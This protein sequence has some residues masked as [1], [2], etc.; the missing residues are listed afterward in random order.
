MQDLVS[1]FLRRA[2]VF[3]MSYASDCSLSPSPSCYSRR[4]RRTIGHGSTQVVAAD[5]VVA[6]K[7]ARECY[8]Y[9]PWN[10][11]FKRLPKHLSHLSKYG[12][13][14]PE[15]QGVVR[16]CVSDEHYVPTVLAVNGLDDEV[17]DPDHP[18]DGIIAA[19]GALLDC[20]HEHLTLAVHAS[21]R[22]RS[23]CNDAA[24]ACNIS[25]CRARTLTAACVALRR[26]TA[27]GW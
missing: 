4:H 3:E 27:M 18:A 15:K 21:V 12:N 13:N 5:E 23:T 16:N 25:A 17:G 20:I 19:G 10:R 2:V 8:T 24:P 9:D 26:R 14:S 6:P 7:F 22:P 1:S 11:V